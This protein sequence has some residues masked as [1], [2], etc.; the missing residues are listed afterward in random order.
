MRLMEG[1]DDE[2]EGL[3]VVLDEQGWGFDGRC[4]EVGQAVLK[5]WWWALE[6]EMISNS[7]R[8]R[9]LRGAKDLQIPVP[10]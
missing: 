4:W 5:D 1:F 6:P 10:G 2:S 9:R 7:N 3:R 8:L